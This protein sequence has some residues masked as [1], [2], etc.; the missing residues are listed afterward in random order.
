MAT[1]DS[2]AGQTVAPVTVEVDADVGETQP[3][4]EDV[5]ETVLE[6]WD[7]ESRWLPDDFVDEAT[8]TG[9]EY[10]VCEKEI[11]RKLHATE[12]VESAEVS[13][14]TY[15]ETRRDVRED[16]EERFKHVPTDGFV[17]KTVIYLDTDSVSETQCT[18]CIGTG[19][20][21]CG[22]CGGGGLATCGECGGRGRVETTRACPRCEGSGVSDPDYDITCSQCAGKGKEVIDDQCPQC[23]GRG[24]IGCP[25]CGGD[26]SFRCDLCEGEG[27][28]VKL[29][30]IHRQFEPETVVDY[31]AP[32]VPESVLTDAD[33]D[34]IETEPLP[35]H[36]DLPKHE[37]ERREIEVVK[38]E[39][40]YDAPSLL[41]WFTSDDGDDAD[42]TADSEPDEWD[43]YVVDGDFE[44]ESYPQGTHRQLL[45]VAAIILIVLVAIGAV[46]MAPNFMV[47]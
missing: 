29:D 14:R 9:A 4:A 18:D 34:H 17:E 8:V 47:F 2:G 12:A 7:E 25:K 15:K 39:Y 37:A 23:R 40:E 36:D 24:E 33:G 10:I 3:V 45:T 43:V 13:R 27:Y 20:V 31:H 26:G 28:T 41:D 44:H 35:T 21:D 6:R 42:T 32:G 19:H 1:T 5:G 30:L 38:V 16:Y 22:Y 46:V 11:E